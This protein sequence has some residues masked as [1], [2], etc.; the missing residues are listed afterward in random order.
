MSHDQHQILV[1][2]KTVYGNELIYPRCDISRTIA[3]LAK[4]KTFDRQD[5]E[6]IK[7]IGFVVASVEVSI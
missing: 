7:R 3:V 6:N 1:E 5:I 2:V 4:K